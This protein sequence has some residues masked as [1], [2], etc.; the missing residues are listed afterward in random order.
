MKD[1]SPKRIY[2][3][4][5]KHMARLLASLAARELQTKTMMSYHYTLIRTAKIKIS[6]NPKYSGGYGEPGSL[7]Y[8]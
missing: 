4:A 6:Y 1:I 7:V 3:T 8:C 5:N 2:I